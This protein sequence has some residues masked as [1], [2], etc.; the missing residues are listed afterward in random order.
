MSFLNPYA[1]RPIDLKAGDRLCYVIVAVI[2]HGG[3]WPAYRGLA[4]WPPERVA[5]EG[6]K[7]DRKEAEAVFPV[8]VRAGLQYRER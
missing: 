1:A 3:D 6:D 2:G 4:D 8:C 5:L 7:L